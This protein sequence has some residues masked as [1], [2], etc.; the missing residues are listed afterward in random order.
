MADKLVID[1]MID[2]IFK[3]DKNKDGFLSVEEVREYM[4]KNK[5]EGEKVL[6]D[7]IQDFFEFC[8]KNKDNKISK[9]ELRKALN[10]I[11]GD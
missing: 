10:G 9:D 6:E 1:M 4:E 8:D 11:Y 2:E 7:K 5:E 3:S